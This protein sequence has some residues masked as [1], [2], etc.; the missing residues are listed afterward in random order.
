ME[1]PECE[2]LLELIDLKDL[3]EKGFLTKKK[4]GRNTYYYPTLAVGELFK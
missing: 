2:L 3:V 1:K 4:F